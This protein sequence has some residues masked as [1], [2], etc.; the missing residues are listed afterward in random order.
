MY[1]KE[2]EKNLRTSFWEGFHKYS[3]P[4]RRKLG[5]PRK[6]MMQSTGIKAIDLKF[7]IDSKLASVGIDV[8]VKSLDRKVFLWN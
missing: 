1:T 5:K 6:W 3:S 7:H 8:V 4:K 2:E